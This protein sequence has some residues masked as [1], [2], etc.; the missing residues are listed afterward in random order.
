[1]SHVTNNVG[2]LLFFGSA[3]YRLSGFILSIFIFKY[4]LFD[5]FFCLAGHSP[6]HAESFMYCFSK[7]SND[8]SLYNIHKNQLIVL[9]LY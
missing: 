9:K 3:I 5:Y 7:V 2:A 6:F 8:M 1:M 4:L